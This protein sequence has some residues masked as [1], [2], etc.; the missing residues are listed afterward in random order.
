MSF[1]RLWVEQADLNAEEALVVPLR[2][3][4]EAMCSPLASRSFSMQNWDGT[5]DFATLAG[6]VARCHLTLFEIVDNTRS[7]SL[8]EKL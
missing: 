6:S 1:W 7:M 4:F 5:F 8:N 3:N 2:D